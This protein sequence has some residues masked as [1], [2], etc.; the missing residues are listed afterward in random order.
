MLLE[1][2][3]N[4][5]NIWGGDWW[6]ANL[7]MERSLIFAGYEVNHSWGEGGHNVKDT[8]AIFPTRCAGCGKIGRRR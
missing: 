8:T 2:G 6:M 7:E 3:S 5:Q 1:D 4:D